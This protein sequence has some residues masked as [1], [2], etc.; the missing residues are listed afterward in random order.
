MLPSTDTR[1]SAAVKEDDRPTLVMS[2]SFGCAR[3]EWIEVAAL[4]SDEYR[5]VT[6]DAPGFGEARDILG[7]SDAERVAHFAETL[8]VLD[9]NRYVLVGHSMTGRVMSIL[10]S[11]YAKQFKLRP[12]ERLVLVTPTPLCPEPL[13]EDERNDFLAHGVGRDNAIAFVNHE[14]N[15]PIPPA[16]HARAVEDFLQ[17]NPAAWKAWLTSGTKED[18]VD[19]CAPIKVETLVIA[20]EKDPGWGP[21]LQQKLTMPHLAHGRMEVVPGSGHLIPM[22]APKQLAALLRNFAVA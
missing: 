20:A 11:R 21:E 5:T 19:R 9:L 3:R 7:Y 2:H 12:P 8:R 6:I 15:L 10:S 1:P 17:V 4:L 22:E 16:V 13:T 18:W 14:S